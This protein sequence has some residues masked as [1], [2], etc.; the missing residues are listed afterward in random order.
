MGAKRK[1]DKKETGR[2]AVSK[3]CL[4]EVVKVAVGLIFK[5]GNAYVPEPVSRS[6]RLRC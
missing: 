2:D 5:G 1:R 3:A 6:V 4:S